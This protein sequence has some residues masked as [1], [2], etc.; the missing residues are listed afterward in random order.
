MDTK[1][2]AEHGETIAAMEVAVTSAL[3]ESGIEVEA[4]TVE[5]YIPL[6]GS[7][8]DYEATIAVRT[9]SGIT[10]GLIATRIDGVVDVQRGEMIG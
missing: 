8:D 10:F 5:T 7:T 4:V 3:N 1:I 2:I 6:D 9:P